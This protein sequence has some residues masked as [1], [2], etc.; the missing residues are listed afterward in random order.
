[1]VVDVTQTELTGTPVID[2]GIPVEVPVAVLRDLA[3]TA[4]VQAVVVAGGIV[5]HA[6]GVVDLGRTCRV[7][8]RAQRRALRGLYATCAIPGCA[9]KYDNCRLHH[10]DWWE[11][12]GTTD[13]HNLL[14]VCE[15]HHHCVHDKGW[16]LTLGP[17]RQLRVETPDGQVMT[18]GPPDRRA[19]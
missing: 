14:P 4:D 15:R 7:A 13:L 18:T 6:P 1:M 2:W 12:G 10:I 11:H 8:S 5:W 19:A 16:T 9:V 17:R 3:G